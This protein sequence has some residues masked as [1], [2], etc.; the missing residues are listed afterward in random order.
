TGYGLPSVEVTIPLSPQ[1][2]ILMVR[3]SKQKYMAVN[4]NFVLNINRR[5]AWNGE[6]FIISS[7]KTRYAM[8]LASWASKSKNYPKLNREAVRRNFL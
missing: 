2:S 1:L 3:K 6:I 7:L 5:T 8:R 4:K